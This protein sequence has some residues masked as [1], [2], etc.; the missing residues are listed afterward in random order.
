MEPLDL[1]GG[2]GSLVWWLLGIGVLVLVVLR[3][4][5]S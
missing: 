1:G 5:L 2:G 3:S 4:R